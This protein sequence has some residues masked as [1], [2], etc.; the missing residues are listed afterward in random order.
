[1]CAALVTTAVPPASVDL[2]AVRTSRQRTHTVFV[3]LMSGLCHR[4]ECRPGSLLA[5]PGVRMHL[6]W[7]AGCSSPVDAGCV[8]SLYARSDG[9]LSAVARDASV[10]TGSMFREH[11][12]EILLSVLVGIYPEVELLGQVVIPFFMILGIPTPFSKVAAPF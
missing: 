8:M 2:T 10:N 5:V 9:H 11:L 4:E 3:S 7:K 6:L 12:F 1:M